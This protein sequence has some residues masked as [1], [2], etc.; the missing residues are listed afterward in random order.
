MADFTIKNALEIAVKTE[1]LGDK[2]YNEMSKRFGDNEDLSKVFALLGADEKDHEKQFQ[3]LLEKYEGDD[4][5]ISEID[6][7]YLKAVS[8]DKYFDNLENL[9]D[10]ADI[11]DVLRLA[12]SVEKEAVLF[13]TGIRDAIGDDIPELTA[14]INI[15]KGHL[16]K[17]MKYIVSESEFRGLSDTWG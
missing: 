6:Q 3:A 10:D 14:I 17:V 5:K 1:Q 16:T 15:E 9:K 13:F 12:Y 4:R 11:I 2:F 7:E 8:L